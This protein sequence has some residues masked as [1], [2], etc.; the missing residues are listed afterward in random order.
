MGTRRFRCWGI[1][2][3]QDTRRRAEGAQSAGSA[4]GFEFDA[5][6]EILDEFD[7]GI[8]GLVVEE[9]PV[10]HHHG[11][12]VAGRVALDMFDRDPTVGTGV[13]GFDTEV[14]ADRVEDLVPAE[15]RTQGVGADADQVF[16]GRV[17]AVHRVEGGYRSNLCG[18]EFE[19]I[20]AEADTGAGDES[21]FG[22]HEVQQG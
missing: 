4:A 2:S 12:E 18:S 20:C 19:L 14:I 10:H 1:E 5:C 7:C 11:G 22:L 13:A 6:A 16:T 17:S 15:R 8:R 3:R 9:L 21:V